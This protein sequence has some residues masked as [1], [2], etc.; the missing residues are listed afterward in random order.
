MILNPPFKYYKFGLVK[1][2]SFLENPIELNDDEHSAH[3]AIRKLIWN[4][5]GSEEVFVIG[6]YDGFLSFYSNPTDIASP[7]FAYCKS[8][9][10]EKLTQFADNIAGIYKIANEIKQFRDQFPWVEFL[11]KNVRTLSEMKR[12]INDFNS[13]SPIPMVVFGK[14]MPWA[15]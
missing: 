11:P 8:S 3:S 5:F 6:N 9:S 7:I 1:E 12:I 2:Y 4:T 10:K 13:Y 15:N 14:N